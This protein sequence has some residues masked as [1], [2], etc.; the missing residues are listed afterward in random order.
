MDI[1]NPE[2][3]T[4]NLY[5]LKNERKTGVLGLF[6]DWALNQNISSGDVLVAIFPKI[7]GPQ[8]WAIIS[9]PTISGPWWTRASPSDRR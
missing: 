7:V 6:V 2:D 9:S 5:Y 1:V 8:T 4:S 3:L